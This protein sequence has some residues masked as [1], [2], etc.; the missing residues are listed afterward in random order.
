MLNNGSLSELYPNFNHYPYPYPYPR[1]ESLSVIRSV[2]RNFIRI[3]SVIRNFMFF[4]R[5]RIR[6]VNENVSV[7]YPYPLSVKNGT[8]PFRNP[9][10]SGPVFYT[11]NNLISWMCFDSIWSMWWYLSGS[12]FCSHFQ[13][14]PVCRK[15]WPIKT[16][17]YLLYTLVKNSENCNVRNDICKWLCVIV[18]F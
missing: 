16:R 10:P 6:S 13:F 7:P 14:C 9:V 8:Y 12:V 4:I 5:I 15:K 3:R 2:I 11:K 1:F 17:K 18:T